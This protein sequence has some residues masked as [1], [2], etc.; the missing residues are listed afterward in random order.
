M[1]VMVASQAIR[2]ETIVGAENDPDFQFDVFSFCL[3]E[4]IGR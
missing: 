4:R 1:L 3:L 2:Q